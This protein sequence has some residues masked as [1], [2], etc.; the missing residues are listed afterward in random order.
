MPEAGAGD[1]LVAIDETKPTRTQPGD[2]WRVGRHIVACLD[3]TDAD[4]VR[5]LVAG[6]KV[7]MVWADPPYGIAVVEHS[8]VLKGEG[9][10]NQWAKSRAYAP[11][12]GDDS[13]QTAL[14]AI[15]IILPLGGVQFWWGANNYADALSPSTCWIVWDKENGETDFADV[16]LAWTNGSGAARIFRH[17]WAGLMKDS[18]RGT[19]RTHPNQ[20]P[21]A[22]C[23][24]AF[25]K[26]GEPGDLILDPFL[27][28]GPSLKAAEGM[29]R[30]V[31]G[32]ELSPAYCDHVIEWAEAEGLTVEQL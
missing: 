27:G 21:I 23:A 6:R 22:L 18:E 29:G 14:R 20:K 25:D 15:D 32:F 31:I 2:V 26:Y 12:I 9:S 13:T 16:E 28:S 3:S 7:G 24:W 8:G 30:T 10:R 19:A 5:R 4:A 17:M 11:V 1:P